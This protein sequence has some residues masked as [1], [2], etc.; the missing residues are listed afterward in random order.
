MFS[1]LPGE[2]LAA[3][4]LNHGMALKFIIKTKSDGLSRKFYTTQQTSIAKEAKILSGMQ[5]ECK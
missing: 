2:R 3:N 5:S 4:S 1:S